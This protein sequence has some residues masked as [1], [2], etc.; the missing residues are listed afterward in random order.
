LFD[1]NGNAGPTVWVGGRVVGGWGQVAD[2]QVVVELL[3]EID[4]EAGELIGDMARALTAWLDGVVVMP[5]FP[6]PMGRRL[7]V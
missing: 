1:T 5:R 7:V 3:E 4:D 6:S 2:G